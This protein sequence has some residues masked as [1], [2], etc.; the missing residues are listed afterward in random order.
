MT[1][2][3]GICGFE[4]GDKYCENQKKQDKHNTHSTPHIL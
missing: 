3:F 1:H 2:R 4:K